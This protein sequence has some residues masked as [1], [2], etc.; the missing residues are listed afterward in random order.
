VAVDAFANMRNGEP[1]S[2]PTALKIPPPVPLTEDGDAVGGIAVGPTGTTDSDRNAK[3]AAATVD[4]VTAPLAR[5][6]PRAA[7]P[8]SR[9]SAPLRPTCHQAQQLARR[10][11]RPKHAPNSGGPAPG[12]AGG[13]GRSGTSAAHGCE[14]QRSEAQHKGASS[15]PVRQAGPSVATPRRTPGPRS[16]ATGRAAFVS[17][18]GTAGPFVAPLERRAVQREGWKPVRGETRTAGT[19][20]RCEAQQPGPAKR[21]RAQDRHNFRG[22]DR[23]RP[24]RRYTRPLPGIT[25]SGRAS[26]P[27]LRP[28]TVA[29]PGRAARLHGRAAAGD[30]TR[31]FKSG[32]YRE[33]I[34]VQTKVEQWARQVLHQTP[35]RAARQMIGSAKAARRARR[36]EPPQ[37]RRGEPGTPDSRRRI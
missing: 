11:S 17:T 23:P 28:A 7:R 36:A 2:R 32:T 10:S 37:A 8:C 9:G 1:D 34:E 22:L 20:A 19:G 3:R 27:S 6:L 24:V 12:V 15:G 29:R 33:T 30:H 25:D 13:R 18:A 26:S 14:A 35:P 31:F 4:G 21:G 5:R 16:P